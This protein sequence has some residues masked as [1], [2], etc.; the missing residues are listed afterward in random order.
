LHLNQDGTYTVVS[1]GSSERAAIPVELLVEQMKQDI[2]RALETYRGVHYLRRGGGE[3][4]A[5]RIEVRRVVL[6]YEPGAAAEWYHSVLIE[7]GR[8]YAAARLGGAEVEI[9]FAFPRFD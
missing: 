5:W 4:H 7:F 2:R 8:E 1:G 6:C 9:A 3:V